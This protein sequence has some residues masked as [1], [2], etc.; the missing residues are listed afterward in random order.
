M[1]FNVTS[2]VS[3]SLLA[4]Y[5]NL[6]KVSTWR[7]LLVHMPTTISHTNKIIQP[8]VQP[9]GRAARRSRD[10]VEVNPPT[11]EQ[12]PSQQEPRS[13]E[14]DRFCRAWN[15]IVHQLRENDLLSDA[16]CRDLLFGYLADAQHFGRE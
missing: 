6:G 8:H 3:S 2:A 5:S 11:G 12:S 15:E 14:L 4:W 13:K 7:Q 16:E 10:L 1:I 9:R